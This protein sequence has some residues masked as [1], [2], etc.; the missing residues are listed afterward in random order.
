MFN[1]CFL[2][3]VELFILPALAHPKEK[4]PFGLFVTVLEGKD[5]FFYVKIIAK[6]CYVKIR[7]S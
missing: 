6:K 1:G 2:F 5:S 3:Q 4:F 7:V